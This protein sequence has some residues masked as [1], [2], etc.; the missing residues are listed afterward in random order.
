MSSNST[1]YQ[2]NIQNIEENRK[3]GQVALA[4]YTYQLW[5]SCYLILSELNK[6]NTY[7]L[8][9]VEDIDQI[10]SI[11][12]NKDGVVTHI[13]IKYSD[14]KQSSSFL[15][16]VLKNFLEIYLN[17][18]NRKFILVYDFE[19][20]EGHLKKLINDELDSK[21][22]QYWKSIISD[23]KED[24]EK[25]EWDNFSYDE[26]MSVLD[27]KKVPDN[28]LKEN[29]ERLLIDKFEIKTDNV[30]LYIEAI[31]SLCLSK[32]KNRGLINDRDIVKTMS[33]TQ[34]L[35]EKGACNPAAKFISKISFINKDLESNDKSYYEGKKPNISDIVNGLPIKRESLEK[36]IIESI[37][38]NRVTVIKASSGQGKTTLAYQAAYNLSE[39]YTSYQ[40]TWCNDTKELLNILNYFRTRVK[41]GEKPLI[42]LDN[43]DVQLSQWNRLAQLLQGENHQYKIIITTREDDWYRYGG[44][45]S[46]IKLLNIVDLYLSSEEANNIYN[47]LDKNNMLHESIVNWEDSY[48]IIE[49]KKLL[50]E[51]V[52]LLTHG[53]MLSQ[54]IDSQIAQL[55]KEDDGDIKGD[56]LRKVCFADKCGVRIA[57][58]KL[59]KTLKEENVDIGSTLESLE[60]EYL[61][62]IKTNDIYVEGL[63]PVRSKHIVDKL[64]KFY[65]LE[66][67]ALEVVNLIDELYRPKFYYYLTYEIKRSYRFYTDLVNEIWDENDMSSYVDA[68]KGIFSASVMK[69]YHDNKSIFDKANDIGGLQLL[70]FELTPFS[71]FEEIDKSED[72]LNNLKEIMP[73]SKSKINNLI[74]LRDDAPKIEIEDTDIYLLSKCIFE[75]F[76]TKRNFVSTIDLDSFSTIMYWLFRID[77]DFNL[78]QNIS[79]DELWNNIDN[80]SLE[81]ISDIMYISWMGNKESY[82]SFV[83]TNLEEILVLLRNRTKSLKIHTK[84]TDNSIHV[85]YLFLFS[86]Q[87]GGNK[88]SV[89]RLEII[90]KALPIFD[91]YCAESVKPKLDILPDLDKYDDSC[92]N[93]PIDNLVIG[94]NRE[95]NSLWIDTILSNYEAESI[96]EW[97]VHW[98]NVRSDIVCLI[99]LYTKL[100][101]KILSQKRI[102]N[103]NRINKLEINLDNNI[104]KEVRYPF[105]DRPFENKESLPEG[106]SKIKSDYF[107]RIKNLINF[108]EGFLNK[109]EKESHLFFINLEYVESKLMDMQFYFNSISLNNEILI[110]EHKLI[111][112]KEKD[113]FN[114]FI[115][116]CYY[117][118]DHSPSKYFSKYQVSSRYRNKYKEK[119]ESAK[120]S[121]TSLS[122][123]YNIIFP[124]EDIREEA[125]NH[126]PIIISGVDS[127]DE[128]KLLNILYKSID[129]TKTDYD[130][131]ILLF[132]SEENNILNLGYKVTRKLLENLRD[133]VNGTE[134]IYEDEALMLFPIEASQKILDCFNTDYI[135]NRAQDG[136]LDYVL[137]IGELLW[138][139][140]TSREEIEPMDISYLDG[141]LKGY[142]ST[143][144]KILKE[145][146]DDLN[147][148]IYDYTVKTCN[149]VYE[150]KTFSNREFNKFINYIITV[151][152]I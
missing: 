23:I 15:K 33:D 69:Y 62:K 65:P 8:E 129:F 99:E 5:Y 123:E 126:Y 22:N 59:I 95:L 143:I 82:L 73:G 46:N 118:Q 44:D 152:K 49:D 10:E 139:I 21:S 144:N 47:V 109:E 67:T 125:L 96:K 141:I 79:L 104:S 12:K 91:T 142:K 116:C 80:Y 35:I 136:K 34:D 26:F 122:S 147:N 121:L 64:H 7:K 36:Q 20:R 58:N 88:E 112:R 131:L 134:I 40:I 25:W 41:F 103:L 14:N 113:K 119:I 55:L 42:I 84:E 16:N 148:Y 28:K 32:M 111:S 130:Y 24:N 68:L 124:K 101:Y 107:L 92:K 87:L 57:S 70:N 50:I 9:G 63:H 106:L 89:K 76:N 53:E 149:D 37:E 132:N 30:K 120:K 83:N 140:S 117:Y 77:S 93:I 74:K 31:S 102:S 51:Y 108:F 128:Y 151:N 71:V 138:S 72:T 45:L 110:E 145:I 2:Q 114:K 17:D 61:I 11:E 4:G 98:L 127:T 150:G 48:K 100:M 56:I 75:F 3:G 81:A 13:Q 19:V 105:Q 78:S 38:E 97:I 90:C 137:K 115:E 43:L 1:N 135:I 52:Y 27:F 60:N 29:I 6:R 94:F 54:R 39:I 85:R 86:N 66:D 133:E 18:N 146:K